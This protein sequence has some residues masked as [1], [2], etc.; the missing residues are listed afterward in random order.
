MGSSLDYFYDFYLVGERCVCVQ[1]CVPATHKI[2]IFINCARSFVNKTISRTLR[3]P[4]NIVIMKGLQMLLLMIKN[5]KFRGK[6]RVIHII[7]LLDHTVRTT[8]YG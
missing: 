4:N 6:K 8:E 5:K 2:P 7:R 3:M 1:K